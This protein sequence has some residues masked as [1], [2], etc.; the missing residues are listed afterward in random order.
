M[1]R[2]PTADARAAVAGGSFRALNATNPAPRHLGQATIQTEASQA[3]AAIAIG[4][5]DAVS[6]LIAAA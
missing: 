4:N 5:V 1:R 2:P 3:P 6:G